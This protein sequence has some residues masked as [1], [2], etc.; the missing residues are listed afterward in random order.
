MTVAASAA[1][2][3]AALAAEWADVLVA[4]IGMPGEDGYSLIRRVR[5]LAGGAEL[6]AIALTAYAGDGDRRRALDAGFQ[7]H[8]AKPVDPGELLAAVLALAGAF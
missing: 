7:V 5:G 4:D 2:A 1:E 6:P 3:L 8:L